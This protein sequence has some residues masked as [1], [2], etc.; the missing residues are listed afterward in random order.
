M[1]K[2]KNQKNNNTSGTNKPED[3]HLSIQ[4]SL[5][6]FSFCIIN[7]MT[8]EV[9][10][11]HNRSFPNY[12][13]TPDK[14][15]DFVKEVF[16]TEPLLDQKY[17]SVNVTHVNDLSTL[18]PRAL[19]D[20]NN[21]S[22]YL[23]YSHKIYKN[24]FISFD[25]I[26]SHDLVNVYIPFVNINNY[27]LEQFGSFDYEHSSTVFVKNLLD[28]YKFSEHPHMFVMVDHDHFEI[29]AI[30][31][32]KLQLYN[33]FKYNTPQDFIYYLLFV[34]EQLEFNPREFEMIFLGKTVANDPIYQIA[35]KYVKNITF[36][37]VR[38]KRNL[39]KDITEDLQRQYFTLL[40]QF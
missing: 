16:K 38:N 36:L 20:E 12:S 37:E 14:H 1:A 9:L 15:L 3:T 4:L 24:D 8:D 26:P 30:A 33:Y 21:L 23:K 7:E 27:F 32:N 29:L 39:N 22:G 28:T 2:K 18:V 34:A 6:G 19:F 40:H 25:T 17:N 10:S 13:Y 11:L 31:D 5:D 35:Y